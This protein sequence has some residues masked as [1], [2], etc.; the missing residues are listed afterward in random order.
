MLE[1]FEARSPSNG[2]KL[3][4]IT[5]ADADA[6]KDA[7]KIA[8]SVQTLWKEKS[9]KFKKQA[10]LSLRENIIRER[11]NL[12]QLISE[13][14]GKPKFE[15]LAHEILPVVTM[16]TFFAHEA[17]K[18]LIPENIP[19][20]IMHHRRSELR[21][22]PLGVIAVISPWNYPFL[23]PLGEIVM[24]VVTGNAVIFKPSEVTT[25]IGKKIQ[26]L[27]E[28]AGFPRGLVQTVTGDGRTGEA[29]I[30][31]KPEKIFFTGSVSTGKKILKAAAE[32]LIPVNL[33][34]GG[35]DPMIVLEDAD[36]DL[37]TSA[38]VWG[39]FS[40]L[41]QIC[42]SVER[43]IVHES[44]KDRFIEQF[45]EK[46]NR[47]TQGDPSVTRV[48]LGAI[49]FEKQKL[50]YERQLNDARAQNLTFHSGGIF[51]ADRRYLSPTILSGENIEK[52]LV[53]R[54]ETFGPMVAVTSFQSIDE[55]IE[56]ANDTNYGLL[57]S[58]FTK[59]TGLGKA[60][61]HKLEVGT[62]TINEVV[63]TAG[64]PETPWGGRKDSGYGR[65]HSARGLMDFVH[66][67][68]IHSPRFPF[69]NFKSPWWY[70]Y[71]PFQYQVFDTGY[72]FYRK[73]LFAKLRNIPHFLWTLLQMIKNEPRL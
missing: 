43:I 33:E 37:A 73:S 1:T 11:E 7:Y 44:I 24:A 15:A 59:N 55:A 61:A 39:S 68:H 62:V 12:A 31:E 58:V 34:L 36:L 42:A 53:Y 46:T 66:T 17:E 47:L 67:K 52:A 14:N 30:Q 5:I 54:E 60:I 16:I 10:L 32:H 9:P 48:D 27:F 38:A 63:Y 21:H 26:A 57:A 50:I 6:V 72:H 65:K 8:R 20:K 25:L 35:K 69:L 28:S 41:G 23:L 70:P 19:M 18:H 56:K 64:L 40:N 13:E 45:I 49:T 22:E 4:D 51:S 3:E 29:V 71:T 2:K